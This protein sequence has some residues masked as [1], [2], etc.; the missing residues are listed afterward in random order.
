MTL[1]NAV[2]YQSQDIQYG[3][4]LITN[5]D[6]LIGMAVDDES[7]RYTGNVLRCSSCHLQGGTQSYGIALVGVTDRFPQFRGREN[8]EGTLSERIN[9][10][11]TRSM[12]GIQLPEDGKEMKSML[13]YISWLDDY[14][15]EDASSVSPGLKSIELPNRAVDLVRGEAIFNQQ[16]TVCHQSN[17]QG[18][19]SSE[20]PKASYT[21]PPLWGDFSYNN[22]AGMHRVITAAQFIKYNMP[23]GITHESAVL[24]DED[25]YDVAGYMNSPRSSL[26]RP[27][28]FGLS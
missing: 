13:A 18:L 28:R 7:M 2:Q 12:N 3:Y 8:K 9:G 25:A 14:F 26:E 17:G 5:T 19:A 23:F 22:G 10:C 20:G 4:E 6:Q 15:G 16:C 27:F 1:E 11:M 24:S 21:Y